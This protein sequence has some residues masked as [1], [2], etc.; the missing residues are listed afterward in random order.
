MMTLFHFY[1]HFVHFNKHIPDDKVLSE[2]NGVAVL[3]VFYEIGNQSFNEA[4][5]VITDHLEKIAH[6]G[7][8]DFYYLQS[9]N[10]SCTLFIKSNFH[11]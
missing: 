5:E 6:K 2:T 8:V 3:G 9:K 10:F 4:M 11:R 1:V 7:T